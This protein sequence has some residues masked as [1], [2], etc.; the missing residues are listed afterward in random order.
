MVPPA[1]DKAAKPKKDNSWSPAQSAELYGVD[2]WGHGFFGVN[3]KGH[4][5]VKLQRWLRRLS[6]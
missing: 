3:K 4:V 1:T 2:Q 5:T 6:L